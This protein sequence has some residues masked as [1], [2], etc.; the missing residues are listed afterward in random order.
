MDH[1]RATREWDTSD[2]VAG[3]VRQRVRLEPAGDVSPAGDTADFV[4]DVRTTPRAW[5]PVLVF[6]LF[7]AFG[8]GITLAFRSAGLPLP[9]QIAFV[10]G[11]STLAGV[12]ALAHVRRY[13]RSFSGTIRV[14]TNSRRVSTHEG[15][16]FYQLDPVS[17]PEGSVLVIDAFGYYIPRRGAAFAGDFDLDEVDRDTGFYSVMHRVMI[18]Q[19]RDGRVP[20]DAAAM[21][22]SEVYR[23]LAAHSRAAKSRLHVVYR[24]SWGI[25]SPSPALT[26][27]G[28][29]EHVPPPAD[30]TLLL[31]EGV[32]PSLARAIT[33]A[34]ALALGLPVLDL[35][36]REHIYR[37]NPN[38]EPRLP[39]SRSLFVN[40]TIPASPAPAP[41]GLEL[42]KTEGGYQGAARS[43][44]FQGPQGCFLRGF[45]IVVFGGLF[46]IAAL[47]GAQWGPGIPIA[48]AVFLV[49]IILF[50]RSKSRFVYDPQ[51]GTFRIYYPIP[52]VPPTRVA[53]ADLERVCTSNGTVFLI[54]PRDRKRFR[55]GGRTEAAYWIRDMLY[56]RP[57][58]VDGNK[59]WP[60]R[61]QST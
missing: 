34:I 46:G 52:F 18:T 26:K 13:A 19:P 54:G 59:T 45:I 23:S 10:F 25:G 7:L 55:A 14:D 58:T 4:I 36:H 15:L 40:L 49:V 11:P 22:E 35:V 56:G 61:G 5:L 38:D 17:V 6:S 27:Q 29:L 32:S 2:S 41:T 51:G 57:V 42:K 3:T 48:V 39:A 24:R 31:A 30:S 28:V 43:S 9:A 53:L 20:P 12:V 37:A 21:A 47:V 60:V 50:M 8:I 33:E 16:S 44:T 1:P